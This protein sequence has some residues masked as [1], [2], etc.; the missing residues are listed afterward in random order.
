MR[1]WILALL[2]VGGCFDSIVSAGCDDG[3]VLCGETCRPAAQCSDAGRPDVAPDAAPDAT[4][5]A[6]AGEAC[7][8]GASLCGDQCVVLT[9]DSEH[10]GA[11][12]TSCGASLTC[13]NGSCC[14]EDTLGCRGACIDPLSDPDHCG[15][16][17]ISCPSGI[18]EHGVC[19]GAPVGHLVIIGHDHARTRAG[20]NRLLGN[21]VFLA[22]TADVA[23]ATYAGD[24]RPEAASGARAAIDQVAHEI[25][26]AW[27]E[28]AA[29]AASLPS[30]LPQ[31][32]ALV[33]F[34]QATTPAAELDALA[35]LWS[36][37][38]ATFLARGGIVVVLEG[39]GAETHRVV[40][41]RF[42][43]S[44]RVEVTGTVMQ[45]VAPRDALAAAV[46]SAYMAEVRSVAFE[47]TSG[48]AVVVDGGGRAVVLHH[49]F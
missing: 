23:V 19:A 16:C 2:F 32:D 8:A 35:T 13:S 11:C 44:R 21:A 14:S 41:A 43:A 12:G 47:G 40:G 38:L 49:T 6:A 15:A 46:P 30:V 33:V 3:Y 34:A 36:P 9:Q 39:P 37:A 27:R 7:G 17:G 26:R 29:T 25:G 10:C 1:A 5:D 20:M 28:V 24:A 22:R 48:A 4:T 18:C 45:V 42:A 31:V